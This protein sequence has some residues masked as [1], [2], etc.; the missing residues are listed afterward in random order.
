[1][2]EIAFISRHTLV[3]T[4]AGVCDCGLRDSQPD[5]SVGP[6]L[7]SPQTLLHRA[8]EVGHGIGHRWGAP[9]HREREREM[10]GTIV[11]FDVR[12]NFVLAVNSRCCACVC[13]LAIPGVSTQ[14][15]CMTEKWMFV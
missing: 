4:S 15:G 7:R 1:M 3:E 14:P 9:T 11:L 2:P 8:M 10:E 12:I 13:E 6:L 5:H